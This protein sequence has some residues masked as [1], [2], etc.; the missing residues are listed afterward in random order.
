MD[1]YYRIPIQQKF[2]HLFKIKWHNRILLYKCLLFGLSTGLLIY[3]KFANLIVWACIYWHRS[4]FKCKTLFNLLYYLDDFVGG[5]SSF[6]ISKIQMNL[7]INLF[8]KLNIPTNKSKCVGL[9]QTEIILEWK[10]TT[11]PSYL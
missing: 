8:S 1:A 5:N 2:Y 3:N 7:L 11:I 10:C 6:D 9:T 4:N